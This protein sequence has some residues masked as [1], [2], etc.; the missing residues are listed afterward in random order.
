MNTMLARSFRNLPG[1]TA[2]SLFLARKLAPGLLLLSLLAGFAPLAVAQQPNAG[3]IGAGII[4]TLAGKYGSALHPGVTD[5][6][7][8]NSIPIGSGDD[9]NAVAIDANGNV[10][11]AVGDNLNNYAYVGIIYEGGNPPLLGFRTHSTLTPGNFY[12]IVGNVQITNGKGSLIPGLCKRGSGTCGDG[13]SALQTTQSILNTPKG[14]A[15][16][17]FGNLYISDQGTSS[18]RKVQAATGLIFTEVGDPQHTGQGY[19]GEN[20][21]AKGSLLNSPG[22]IALDPSGDNLYIA[23]T[24]NHLVR[25]VTISATTPKIS[26]VAG[27]PPPSAGAAPGHADDPEE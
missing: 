5:D 4:S 2:V 9:V 8:A 19:S 11:V 24:F 15:L 17:Q 20:V 6:V 1:S 12:Y 22:G 13:M 21:T 10:Y 3:T 23:E 16:D 27:T 26:T 25:K 14:L 7:P 18:I